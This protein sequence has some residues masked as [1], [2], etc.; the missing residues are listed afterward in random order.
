MNS[1]K[2]KE[3]KGR[4]IVSSLLSQIFPSA[5]LMFT[6]KGEEYNRNILTNQN[7]DMNPIDGF[8]SI[9]NENFS[10][11]IKNRSEEESAYNTHILEYDKLEEQVNARK[12]GYTWSKNYIDEPVKDGYYITVWNT[13]DIFIYRIS[14]I[15]K[16]LGNSINSHFR[17]LPINNANRR[18]DFAAIKV[19]ELPKSLGEHYKLENYIWKRIF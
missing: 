2:E 15:L 12:D 13:E 5:K 18:N 7:E 19:Y 16:E 8:F 11:E 10:F 4:N 9:G 14:D 1:F 17:K 6:G 3:L